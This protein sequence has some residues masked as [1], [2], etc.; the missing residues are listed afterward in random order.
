MKSSVQQN[1]VQTNLSNIK[2]VIARKYIIKQVK[3]SSIKSRSPIKSWLQTYRNKCQIES[4][5]IYFWNRMM[6]QDKISNSL[7]EMQKL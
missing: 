7:A 4:F 3:I 1:N 5:K 2:K 6:S